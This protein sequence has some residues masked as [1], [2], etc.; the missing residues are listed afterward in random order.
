MLTGICFCFYHPCA[1]Y[2][3]IVGGP[4]PR[5]SRLQMKQR[6]QGLD[7]RLGLWPGPQVAE[8]NLRGRENRVLVKHP[9][10][11]VMIGVIL[12]L[13]YL[14]IHAYRNVTRSE[15][16]GNKHHRN[17]RGQD[18]KGFPVKR[19]PFVREFFYHWEPRQSL[20]LL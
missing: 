18:R 2:L 7:Q 10:Y 8:A 1:M 5:R 17:S 20:T 13:R 15:L 3:R 12:L 4:A 19:L 6:R 14:L 16:A 9:C 11:P